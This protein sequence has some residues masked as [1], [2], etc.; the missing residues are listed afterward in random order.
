MIEN[1]SKIQF[2]PHP[3]IKIP[4]PS[5]GVDRFNGHSGITAAAEILIMDVKELTYFCT[6]TLEQRISQDA[7]RV[8]IAPTIEQ[9]FGSMWGSVIQ[10]TDDSFMLVTTFLQRQTIHSRN[11]A[12]SPHQTGGRDAD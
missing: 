2:P 12:L 7:L 1:L 11:Q 6:R 8:C 5:T 9:L 10:L 4:Q 3:Q